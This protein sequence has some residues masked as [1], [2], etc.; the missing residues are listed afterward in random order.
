M[1][2]FVVNLCHKQSAVYRNGAK[3]S[4]KSGNFVP[5]SGNPTALVPLG[6]AVTLQTG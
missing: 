5:Q 4:A 2:Y 6:D 1:N 3:K